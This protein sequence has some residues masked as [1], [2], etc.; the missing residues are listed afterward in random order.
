[1]SSIQSIKKKVMQDMFTQ[2]TYQ[3]GTTLQDLIDDFK[4]NPNFAGW[5][6]DDIREYALGVMSDHNQR[7]LLGDMSNSLQLKNRPD[8]AIYL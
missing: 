8:A 3:Q 5:S 2:R 6:D 1:M 7:T 4:T